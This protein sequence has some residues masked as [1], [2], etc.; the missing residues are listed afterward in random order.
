MAFRGMMMLSKES[1]WI[2]RLIALFHTLDSETPTS[3]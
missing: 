3:P 2:Q 1:M